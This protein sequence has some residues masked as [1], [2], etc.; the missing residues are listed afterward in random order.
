MTLGEE[1][2]V[3]QVV[4][5]GAHFVRLGRPH[6]CHI[7]ELTGAAAVHD[8]AGAGVGHVLNATGA[9]VVAQ[10]RVALLEVG[11]SE[12]QNRPAVHVPALD[13]S[14]LLLLLGHHV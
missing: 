1:V 7:V 4:L 5:P 9:D 3:Q 6:R 12:R 10:V 8:V 2:V 11:H 14:K 13:F